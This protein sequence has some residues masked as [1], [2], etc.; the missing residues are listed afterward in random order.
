MRPMSPTK[1]RRTTIKARAMPLHTRVINCWAG[2][3]AGKST[4]KAGIFFQL[5]SAGA[6]AIQIE[7]YATERSVCED[8]ETLANQRKVTFKQEQRQRRFLGKVDW[9][10]TDSPL[11]LG[12]L[13]GQGK[14]ATSEFHQEVWD[15]FGGYDNINIWIDRVKPYQKYARHHD[16]A[17]ARD[18][19]RRLRAICGNRIDLTVPGDI[20]APARVMEYL[21]ERFSSV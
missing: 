10:I 18:L 2:P 16:E 13:Y 9:I 4:T 11:P 1:V 3:G 8:W 5:K 14:F 6:K 17:E 20:F 7:E 19:D 12:I 21:R 15:L